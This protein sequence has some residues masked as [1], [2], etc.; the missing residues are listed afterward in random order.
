MES[1]KRAGWIFKRINCNS[2]N[3]NFASLTKECY[4]VWTRFLLKT[5]KSL[6]SRGNLCTAMC[7][8]YPSFPFH[9]SIRIMH[10]VYITLLCELFFTPT[11]NYVFVMKA[12]WNWCHKKTV[13]KF[14]ATIWKIAHTLGKEG[15]NRIKKPADKYKSIQNRQNLKTN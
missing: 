5:N 9:V 6:F 10:I 12:Y 13:N 4:E 3:E 8:M 7:S 1:E 2:T 11:S 14:A 15:S